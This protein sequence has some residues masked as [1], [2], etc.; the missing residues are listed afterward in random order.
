MSDPEEE[1]V[2][3]FQMKAIEAMK[4]WM[5]E[6]VKTLELRGEI[7]SHLNAA[8]SERIRRQLDAEEQARVRYQEAQQEYEKYMRGKGSV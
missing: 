6:E 1:Q 3:H 4:E 5:A 2:Q 7:G 8:N